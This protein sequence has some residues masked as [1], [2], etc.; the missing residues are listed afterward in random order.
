[1]YAIEIPVTSPKRYISFKH[2]LNLRYPDEDTGEW[3][4]LSAFFNDQQKI[5]SAPVAGD[6]GLVNTTP[7]LGDRGIREMSQVLKAQKV[8]SGKIPVYV[9]NHYRAIADL[10][11]LQILKGQRPTIATA[12]AINSWLDT[13]EQVN[14]LVTKYLI[15]LRSQL[16][17][18]ARNIFDV[19][20][21]TIRYE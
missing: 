14:Q 8:I 11:M 1:M 19:W 17:E 10:A 18:S 6:G 15:P 16:D 20:I 9:A 7:S 12:R 5:K 4:F 13:E 3:H 21:A 2:A